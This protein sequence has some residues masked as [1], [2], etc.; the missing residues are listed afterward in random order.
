MALPDLN[1]FVVDVL[2]QAPSEMKTKEGGHSVYRPLLMG[3]QSGGHLL[4]HNECGACID[5]CPVGA[6][7]SDGHDAVLC[8]SPCKGR[9][10]E[11]LGAHLPEDMQAY[12]SALCMCDTPCS[13]TRPGPLQV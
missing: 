1:Q 6:I 4:G 9:V 11:N 3:V 8:E 12:G 13:L 5:R 7:S 10:P 2:T